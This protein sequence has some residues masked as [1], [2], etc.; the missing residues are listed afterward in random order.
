MN[1]VAFVDDYRYKNDWDDDA[2]SV[3]KAQLEG[4]NGYPGYNAVIT[5]EIAPVAGVDDPEVML[6]KWKLTKEA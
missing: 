1:S 4:E 6:I 5:E 2:R 3:R